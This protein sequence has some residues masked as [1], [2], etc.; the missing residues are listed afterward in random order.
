MTAERTASLGPPARTWAPTWSQ[1]TLLK[2]TT[3]CSPCSTRVSS[4][5][6]HQDV[7]Y[8]LWSQKNVIS[9][10]LL[11]QRRCPNALLRVFGFQ[12]CLW[13]DIKKMNNFDII[14]WLRRTVKGMHV[15]LSISYD[16]V[17]NALKINS[18]RSLWSLDKYCFSLHRSVL[19]LT[20]VL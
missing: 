11:V 2:R 18:E 14:L 3:S 10:E 20:S 6:S 19:C 15:A 9:V 8:W 16:N 12:C 4:G 5:S 7:A 17:N 1:Y 13:I